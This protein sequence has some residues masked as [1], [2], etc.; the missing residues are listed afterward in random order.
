MK[1]LSYS[2]VS[3]GDKLPN[4][5]FPITVVLWDGTT[6]VVEN[7]TEFQVVIEERFPAEKDLPGHNGSLYVN[8]LVMQVN[9]P[10]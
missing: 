6:V 9:L 8:E 3:V 10:N 7:F 5:D 1:T 4:F 2:D